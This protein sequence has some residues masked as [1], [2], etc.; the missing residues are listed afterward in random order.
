M[1]EKLIEGLIVSV[2]GIS[3]TFTVMAFLILCITLTKY[4][5]QTLK[6]DKLKESQKII[7]EIKEC[8]IELPVQGLD[9][10]LV[11]VITASVNYCMQA[12]NE[13]NNAV[14][15]AGFIVR[16]IRKRI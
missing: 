14:P 12:E 10:E 16:A 2:I 5:M 11:A 13:S 6:S 9:P 1:F 7:S 3:L 8:P 4:V 15:K